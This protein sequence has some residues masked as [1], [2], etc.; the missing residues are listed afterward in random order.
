MSEPTT[1][2]KRV[3]GKVV[4]EAITDLHNQEQIVTREVLAEVTGIKLATLDWHIDQLIDSGQ[5]R[6]VKAGV[7]VP[8]TCHKPA[9]SIS[10]SLL[11]DGTSVLEVGDTVLILT[12]REARMI[13]EMFASSASAYSTI[14]AGWEIGMSN[15]QN[16]V[17]I[18]EMRRR[19]DALESGK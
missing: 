10:R 18:R 9:R 14:Q 4:M 16:D 13:G 8:A 12:P 6:R 3:R 15:S 2:A 11:P 5:I 17:L 1:A 19:L 7:F